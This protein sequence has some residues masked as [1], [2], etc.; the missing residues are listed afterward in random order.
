MNESIEK[1]MKE[2]KRISEKGWISTTSNSHGAVGNLFEEELGKKSDDLYF[3]DYFGIELKCTTRYSKYPLYLF[4]SAFDGP[5]FPEIDRIVKK[6]GYYDKDFKDKKVLYEKLYFNSKTMIS[7]KYLFQLELDEKEGKVFLCVYDKDF[8]LIERESFVYI[9][10][11]YNHLCLKLNT[12]AL[13]KAFN[14]EINSLKYFKY[15]YIAI[16]KLISF[17][18]FLKLLK[19]DFIRVELISRISK[20]G[21]TAGRY[22]NKNLVF[23]IEKKD[24]NKLFN[25]IESYNALFP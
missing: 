10:T 5:T 9:S 24:V 18:R 7:D 2:F 25:R 12:L 8:N 15:Y 19:N 6:Y 1:L 17:D 22:R 20:S 16:Y 13:V 3:P 4:T 11:L 21:S 23:S 14:K